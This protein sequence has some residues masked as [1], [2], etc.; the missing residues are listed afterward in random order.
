MSQSSASPN[1]EETDKQSQLYWQ[2][3]Y[4]K[5]MWPKCNVTKV[6]VDGHKL[7]CK[8]YHVFEKKQTIRSVIYVS[9]CEVI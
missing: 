7:F 1:T 8:G 5:L 2:R 6:H 9:I 4:L 3:L